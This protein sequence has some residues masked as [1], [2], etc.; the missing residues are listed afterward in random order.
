[1]RAP[2]KLLATPKGSPAVKRS[3]RQ[4]SQAGTTATEQEFASADPPRPN[5]DVFISYRRRSRGEPV[6]RHIKDRLEQKGFRAFLDVTG[7]DGGKFP[8]RLLSTIDTTR[9]FLVILSQGS[10]RRCRQRGDWLRREIARAI[11][12]D[13]NIVP[14]MVPDFSMAEAEDLPPKLQRLSEYNALTYHHDLF[15]A[16]VDRLVTFLE[17]PH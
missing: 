7:L 9:N 15:D 1:L 8:Q 16:F 6:A 5:Y 3:I 13:R 10:L 17:R 14:V 2:L 4:A 11:A 12:T